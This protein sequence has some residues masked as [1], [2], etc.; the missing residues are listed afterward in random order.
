MNISI[1]GFNLFAKGGTSR[2]NINLIKSLLKDGN[3]I[4]YYNY[5]K[6]NSEQ[7]K[8]LYDEEKIN[9]KKLKI[10]YFKNEKC[11]NETELLIITRESFFHYA[12]LTKFYNPKIKIVGEIHGPLKYITEDI[13][14]AL[15][16][17]DCIRVSTKSIKREFIEK[18]HY[19]NV[20]NQYVNTEHV[21]LE[22]KPRNT[23]KHFLVKARFED[24]IKDISYA[25]KLVNY[26]VKNKLIKDIR[27]N[28]IGYG[29]SQVLYNNL[30]QYYSL[31][32]YVFINEY[33]P[34]NYIYLSTSPYETLGYSIVETLF[35]GNKALLYGG[36]DNV[37]SEIYQYYHGVDFLTKD[38]VQDAEILINFLQQDYTIED[39][40]K[41]IALLKTDFNNNNYAEKYMDNVK[42]FIENERP[43]VKFKPSLFHSFPNF[44]NK[45]NKVVIKKYIKLSYSL[46]RRTYNYLNTPFYKKKLGKISPSANNIFIESFHGKNFS[47]DPKYIA[48][49][50]K[51]QYPNKNVFVSSINTLVDMEIREHG[52]TPVRIGSSNYTNIFRQCKYVFINGNTL[53]KVYKHSSQ[54]FVQTW[55]GFP[56]KRMVNDLNDKNERKDQIR[57]LLPRMK[58]WDYLLV[59][60]KKNKKLLK[61]AFQ[62][63]H[64]NKLKILDYGAPR[65]EYLLKNNNLEEEKRIRRKYL[66]NENLNKKYILYCPTWRNKNRESVI[67]SDLEELLNYLPEEYELIIKLHPNEAY[68]RKYYSHIDKRIHCFYNELVDIQ[69]LYLISTCM[70]TDYSSTIFDYAHLNKPIFL[71]QEDEEDYEKEIGFYFNLMNYGEFYKASP[72]SKELAQQ[73]I[74]VDEVD[75]SNIVNKFMYYDN[76]NTSKNILKAVFKEKIN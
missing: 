30:I 4:T 38:I 8:E 45:I 17:I 67:K 21:V 47:G 65:N 11:F 62:L 26:I 55:H 66:F 42:D 9:H 50:I 49:A 35:E 61:S 20:F 6:F 31:N 72:I 14:L 69:E 41:D 25:I 63:K 18:Y 22:E 33:I 53:D 59:S 57:K 60:S 12:K 71:F 54:V 15:D 73:I 1:L 23:N 58:K 19:D 46:L 56:L 13:D 24:N 37:L 48:L 39:R 5:K 44:K 75:Y 27:L 68:L 3:T 28:I 76:K 36:E 40:N 7:L 2:S 43:V 70:I 52:L 16:Y 64:N 32:D 10:E 34:K 51:G 74:S 29:P